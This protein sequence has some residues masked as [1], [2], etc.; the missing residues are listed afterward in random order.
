MKTIVKIGCCGYGG[1]RGGSKAYYKEFNII[2]VQSTFYN[3][4][5]PETAI[6]WFENAKSINKKFVFTMKAWQAIT[7][8]PSSPTWRR[9]RREPHKLYGN[10]DPNEENFKA[11][12]EILSIARLLKS[13]VIVIQTPPTF[14]LSEENIKRVQTFFSVINRDNILIGWE[15]RGTWLKE[16]SLVIKLCKDLDLLYIFDPLKRSSSVIGDVAYHRLHG[17]GPKVVNYKYKYTQEDLVKLLK[18]LKREAK[19]G[20]KEIY[21]MFNNIYMVQDSRAFIE[22]INEMSNRLKVY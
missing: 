7:H 11:W 9:S 14:G 13:E 17:L 4:P 2:E 1:I 18:A 22:I 5:K 6:K 12:E 3:L 16:E 20:V 19:E 8:P 10:L 21:V 15:P